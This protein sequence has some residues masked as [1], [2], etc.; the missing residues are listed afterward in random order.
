M[1]PTL[2]VSPR[3][4]GPLS[5]VYL[6]TCFSAEQAPDSLGMAPLQA[7]RLQINANPNAGGFSIEGGEGG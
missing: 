4:T 6:C 3:D 1:S 5:T 2:Q 7:Q